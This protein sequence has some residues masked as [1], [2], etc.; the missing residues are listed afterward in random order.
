MTETTLVWGGTAAAREAAIAAAL[1][2]LAR[3]AG[4][5]AA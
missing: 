1:A 5:P 2:A 4:A 3:V